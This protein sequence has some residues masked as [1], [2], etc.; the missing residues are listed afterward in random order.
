MYCKNCGKE[1]GNEDKFC[2]NCGLENKLDPDNNKIDTLKDN[3]TTTDK[4]VP[5][6]DKPINGDNN[7]IS[8]KE[9]REC[10]TLCIIS[11]IC[12]F[13]NGG[14]LSIYGTKLSESSSFSNVLG[15]APLVGVVLMIVARVKYPKKT[16]PKVLMW[17][18]IVNIIIFI[19]FFI[20]FFVLCYGCVS[21]M[22]D[23]NWGSFFRS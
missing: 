13:I 11:L 8:D 10:N 6:G 2:S 18:Y 12:L 16:F 17:I 23:W 3:E 14:I 5:I 7:S 15:L 4:N 1:L 21:S 20:M 22:G 19:I 9:D